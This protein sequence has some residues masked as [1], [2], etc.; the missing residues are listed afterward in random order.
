MPSGKRASMR[1]GPLAAL[2]R[3]TAQDTD[4][5]G[6]QPDADATGPPAT[7]ESAAAADG[8]SRHQ[9]LRRAEP[10]L[11]VEEPRIPLPHERLRH[12]FSADIPENVLERRPARSRARARPSEPEHDVYARVTRDEPVARARGRRSGA[13]RGRRRRRRRERDQPDGRGRDRGRRVPGDQHRS[14]VAPAVGRARDA[15]HRRLD[16]ARAR[17]GFEPGARARRGARG[18]R[19]DQGDAP[20]LGHGVHRRRR[21][22]RN[23]HRR[24][25]DRRP[26]R[27]RARRADRRDRHAPVPVRGHPPARP[28]RGGDRATWPKRSTR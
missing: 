5:H 17:V 11:E 14:S 10:E 22:R 21:G 18:V 20:R 8:A 24:G 12:A 2:F 27:A 6:Q 9:R 15:P 25:A 26:D 7:P 1:E 28:G 13:A 19:P 4:E 16:H 23:G 3:K